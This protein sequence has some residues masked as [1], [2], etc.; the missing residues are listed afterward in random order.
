MIHYLM[1]QSAMEMNQQL[2]DKYATQIH[3]VD[4]RSKPGN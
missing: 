1:M 4:K 3:S 2:V